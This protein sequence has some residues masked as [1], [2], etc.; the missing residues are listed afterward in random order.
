MPG[1]FQITNDFRAQQ[2]HHI[3]KFGEAIAGE[4]F[5][6]DRRAADHLATLQHHHF[7]A[8]ASEVCRSDQAIV[9]GA[10]DDGIV[11]I[12]IHFFFH[13]GS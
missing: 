11:G 12:G 6:G 7:L 13:S 2:T 5:L 10:D 1:Q 4:N 8:G 9:A 3:G